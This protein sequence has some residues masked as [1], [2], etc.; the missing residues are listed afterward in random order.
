METYKR[1]TGPA[2]FGSM[3]APQNDSRYQGAFLQ[4]KIGRVWFSDLK[5]IYSVCFVF[6]LLISF[7]MYLRK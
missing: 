6:R 5:L 3:K 2:H 4:A 1:K 7:S